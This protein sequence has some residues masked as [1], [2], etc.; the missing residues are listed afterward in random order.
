MTSLRSFVDSIH[1]ICSTAFAE[2]NLLRIYCLYQMIRY[3]KASIV[4]HTI[5]T[6][7]KQC[8]HS[9]L[10]NAHQIL[11]F[12]MIIGASSTT[13]SNHFAK[14]FQQSTSLDYV[15]NIFW[16]LLQL[17]FLRF[18]PAELPFFYMEAYSCYLNVEEEMVCY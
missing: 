7:I 5:S 4:W 12:Q 13:I 16:T 2:C 8:D 17:S 18:S 14:L 6:K 15:V 3:M 10:F 1:L 11:F 9:K